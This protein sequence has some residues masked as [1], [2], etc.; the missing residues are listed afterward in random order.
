MTEIQKFNIYI[1]LK[2]FW[3][4]CEKKNKICISLIDL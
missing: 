1:F 3:K 4:N 2:K